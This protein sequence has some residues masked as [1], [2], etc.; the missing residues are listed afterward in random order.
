MRL[1]ICHKISGDVSA[2][3][4]VRQFQDNLQAEG[5]LAEALVEG[6]YQG[7]GLWLHEIAYEGNKNSSK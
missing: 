6:P 5:A 1:S 4:G 7:N 2:V 3:R